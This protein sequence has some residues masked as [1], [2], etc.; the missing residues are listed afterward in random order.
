MYH[1]QVASVRQLTSPPHG[2][3]IAPAGLSAPAADSGAAVRW[4]Q[5]PTVL[6]LDAPL[7]TVIWQRLF[8]ADTGAHLAW[9]HSAI[10][11]ASVW[12]VYAADRWLEGWR[13]EPSRLATPRHRFYHRHRTGAAV[14]WC[15]VFAAAVVLSFARLSARELTAGVALLVPVLAYLLSHQLVHRTSRGRVPKEVCVAGLITAGAALFP[16]VDASVQLLPLAD[17]AVWFFLLVL[18]NCALIGG[19]EQHVDRAHEQESIVRN[20][21]SWA[22]PV[23]M[24]P[25]GLASAAL[26]LLVTSAGGA[27]TVRASAAASAVLLGLLD[28]WEPRLGWEASRL[29][30]DVAL[31]TPVVW[32]VVSSWPGH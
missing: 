25:W 26:L 17:A 19:W 29:L 30:A 4:W 21:P 5:W 18:A 6:S 23:R 9:Y 13:V 12:M 14:I 32:L 7:V 20:H 28:R 11:G 31:M 2:G 22:W 8:A 10:V 15:G 3:A 16:L 1:G 27:A 24:F